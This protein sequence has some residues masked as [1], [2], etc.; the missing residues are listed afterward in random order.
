[1]STD[2]NFDKE[3]ELALKGIISSYQNAPKL[4]IKPAQNTYNNEELRITN[5]SKIATDFAIYPRTKKFNI[6]IKN[7][8]L[9][10]MDKLYSAADYKEESE[11]IFSY[12]LCADIEESFK[13][14]SREKA[15]FII[16]LY[17]RS[18]GKLLAFATIL[19]KDLIVPSDI[20]KHYLY[21]DLI[22]SNPA[23]KYAG[24]ILIEFI[25][26]L[27]INNQM[28]KVSLNSVPQSVNFYKKRG[29]KE[30]F[31]HRSPNLTSMTWMRS[32]KAGKRLRKTRKH[33]RN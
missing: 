6:I 11:Q 13:R 15:D 8:I 33:K 28:Y 31:I 7:T 19:I 2:M 18:K 30:N 22:C 4:N 26:S 27:A 16:C 12:E 23:Y 10:N 14:K 20:Y 3:F 5:A 29:Y 1:M 17:D 24:T 9:N 21:I 25:H 32:Q